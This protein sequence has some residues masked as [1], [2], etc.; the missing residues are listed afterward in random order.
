M[1]NRVLF[2]VLIIALT[3]WTRGGLFGI[4]LNNPVTTF[5]FVLVVFIV[6][7][8]PAM[9]KKDNK[10]PKVI[11]KEYGPGEYHD[12]FSKVGSA[13][14]KSTVRPIDP[15]G[16]PDEATRDLMIEQMKNHDDSEK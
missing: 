11:E 9:L 10:G 2:L 5:V 14:K 15:S 16:S 13:E 8:G 7:F 12:D 1:F 6:V 3:Y 4:S